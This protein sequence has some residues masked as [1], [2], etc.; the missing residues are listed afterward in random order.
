MLILVTHMPIEPVGDWPLLA[1][2]RPMG[3][4]GQRP[5]HPKQLTFRFGVAGIGLERVLAV[6]CLRVG[7][8]QRL[9]MLAFRITS[10]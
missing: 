5:V 7:V 1:A 2:C 9:T 8:L 10:Y 3:P 6:L 4:S